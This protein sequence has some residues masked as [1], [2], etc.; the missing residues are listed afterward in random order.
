MEKSS[1]LADTFSAQYSEEMALRSNYQSKLKQHFLKKMFPGMEDVPP[2]FATV[3]PD[4]FDQRLP[5][6]TLADVEELR[7]DCPDLAA[8]LSVPE[9]NALSNLLA[10]SFNQKL[11]KE[12]GETLHSLQVRQ[13]LQRLETFMSTCFMST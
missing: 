9:S 3:K 8:S 13:R 7:R 5:E 11:T 4:P 6:I 2:A 12:E 10:R 1:T